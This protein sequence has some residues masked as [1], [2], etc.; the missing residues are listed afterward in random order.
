MSKWNGNRFSVYTSEEKSALGLIKEMGEQTN[1]NTDEIERLTESDNKKVSYQEMQEVYKIDKQANFT[2]SWFGLKKPTQS[3]EGLAA[4]VEQLIDETIPGINSSLEQIAINVKNYGAKGDGIND[5][6]ISIK[7]CIDENKNKTIYFP[8]GNYKITSPINVS[9]KLGDGVNILLDH[10]ARIFADSEMDYMFHL[11]YST[12]GSINDVRPR[13]S[14]DKRFFIGGSLDC[15]YKAKTCVRFDYNIGYTFRDVNIFHY[16]EKGIHTGFYNNGFSCEGF[17]NNVVLT[18][19]SKYNTIGILNNSLDNHFTDIVVVGSIIGIQ[20]EKG[21]LYTRVHPI[22][23]TDTGEEFYNSIAFYIKSREGRFEYCYADGY[24]ISFKFDYTP[25]GKLDVNPMIEKPFIYL[26]GS[27]SNEK[28]AFF[29]ERK[30]NVIQVKGGYIKVP[31]TNFKVLNIGDGT[32]DRFGNLHKTFKFSTIKDIVIEDKHLLDKSDLIYSKLFLTNNY[33][34]TYSVSNPFE[35]LVITNNFLKI[36]E[37]HLIDNW[38]TA[39]IDFNLLDQQL[40]ILNEHITVKIRQ[41]SENNGHVTIIFNTKTNENIEIV[42]TRSLKKYSIG[43][44]VYNI[45]LKG[46]GTFPSSDTICINA[47]VNYFD[48]DIGYF[49]PQDFNLFD[50]VLINSLPPNEV[51]M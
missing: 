50:Q 17:F 2:G 1:Y 43:G 13:E 46:K 4:T 7:K 10:D 51:I 37:Y 12:D 42:V 32:L 18:T 8:V 38:K 23:D 20:D 26:W 29:T 45:Y 35:P 14:T 24:R 25:N 47:K 36:G 16:T 39:W 6:T 11:G 49:V 21:G 9:Y 27:N 5:D 22:M 28:Y 31:D 40:G 33:N 15:C 30:D 44:N 3:S 19:W 41:E 48:L 34:N